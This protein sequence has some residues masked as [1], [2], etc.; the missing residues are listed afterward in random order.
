MQDD[1][2]AKPGQETDCAFCRDRLE[3]HALNILEPADRHAVEMHLS[4]CRACGS[5]FAQ[6]SQMIEG[7]S[8]ALGACPD[9]KKRLERVGDD[10]C[11]DIRIARQRDTV[12][13]WSMAWTKAAAV[14]AVGVL[15]FLAVRHGRTM[16]DRNSLFRYGWRYPGV[17]LSRGSESAYPLVRE[18]TL[19][20]FA[21]LG[22][23]NRLV[24]I[25]KRTGKL[26]WRTPFEVQNSS[27]AADSLRVF[28]WRAA[29]LPKRVLVALDPG[30]GRLLWSHEAPPPE[31]PGSSTTPRLAATATGVCWVDGNRL[32]SL[33]A[34]SGRLA[35]TVNL[36]LCAPLS[37]PVADHAYIYIAA[38]NGICAV[39]A[40]DGCVNWHQTYAPPHS[41]ILPPVLACDGEKIVVAERRMAGSGALRCHDPE[42]GRLLWLD[43]VL[44]AVSSVTLAGDVFVRGKGLQAFNGATGAS[45][46]SVE[47]G[48][49]SPVAWA[50]ALL[51]TVEGRDNPLLLALDPHTGQQAWKRSL[52]SSCSGLVVDEGMGYLSA[53][54]GALYALRVV[55]APGMDGPG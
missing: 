29:D 49:C 14:V 43:S 19:L 28:V 18:Q 23:R 21:G 16:A 39:Q 46:W 48:G 52:A 31:S 12:V 47:V 44:P 3:S 5:E 9:S 17:S 6:L 10:L 53:H 13:R 20:A 34:R 40:V 7:F 22:D 33:D 35:W 4:S 45:L 24:A 42:T 51:L 8:A 38:A 32:T 1:K 11:R 55:R 50:G 26:L 25:D 37:G 30:T 15:G 27:I 41:R 54:D 36:E 2:T